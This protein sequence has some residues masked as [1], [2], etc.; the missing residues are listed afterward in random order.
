MPAS[1]P[2]LQRRGFGFTFRI[3]V[4][5]EL[6][7]VM[8]SREI[9][10]ALHTS[11]RNTAIPAPLSLAAS[12]RELF[13]KLRVTRGKKTKVDDIQVDFGYELDMGI[14]G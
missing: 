13:H 14:L 10:K 2:Y 3:S 7:H 5:L 1:T 12:A 8:G 11:N 9:T 4:P 6:R